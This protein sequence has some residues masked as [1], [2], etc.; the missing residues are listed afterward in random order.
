M[1]GKVWR[2]HGVW[3]AAAIVFVFAAMLFAVTASFAP[4]PASAG[5]SALKIGVLPIEDTLPFYVAEKEGYFASEGVSVEL[6]PFS[7]AIERDTALRAGQTDGMI[8]DLLAVIFM[9]KSGVPVAITSVALGE[10]PREGRFAILAAPGSKI[11]SVADLK[12]VPIGISHNSIIEYVTDQLL[13]ANGLSAPEISKLE[14][15]KIPIR[16]DMLL[17]GKLQAATLPDP[18]AALA[19]ARG[20]RVIVSDTAPGPAGNL[21]Q[22]VLAFQK[23]SISGKRAEIRKMYAAYRRAVEAVNA[24]P[25]VYRELLIDKARVPEA[26]KE[27]YPL[28]RYPLPKLPR[29]QDFDRVVKWMLEK[30]LIDKP[31]AYRDLT[32]G[33]FT[34]SR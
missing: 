24:R 15:P 30:K 26:I 6:V 34:V 33:Q 23:R 10:T 3:A 2:A 19:E 18:L 14:I 29:K 25:G 28:P 9:E 8:T 20:A 31:Y 16:L 13:L 17:N 5:G 1:S 22:V 11:Q 7:S 4:A 21:S 12:H 27:T 32:D